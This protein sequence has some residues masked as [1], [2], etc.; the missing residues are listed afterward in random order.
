MTQLI[1][2]PVSDT[3]ILVVEEIHCDEL[4]HAVFWTVFTICCMLIVI[5]GHTHEESEN[6][7]S[8]YDFNKCFQLKHYNCHNI[9]Q[10]IAALVSF[11]AIVLAGHSASQCIGLDPKQTKYIPVLTAAAFSFFWQTICR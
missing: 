11:S 3:T 6:E 4:Q 1:Y 5:M 8:S 10:T 9:I 2:T 7:G